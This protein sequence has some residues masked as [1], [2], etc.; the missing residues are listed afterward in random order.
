[1]PHAVG[2]LNAAGAGDTGARPEEA[3]EPISK[4]GRGS[5]GGGLGRPGGLRGSGWAVGKL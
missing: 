1:M 4:G 3:A 5:L 2:G